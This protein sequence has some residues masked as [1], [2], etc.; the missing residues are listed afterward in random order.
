VTCTE[1]NCTLTNVCV[2][3]PQSGVESLTITAIAAAISATALI[4]IIVGIVA[5][6]GLLGGG[7]AY[8]IAQSGTGG[9][10]AGVTNNPLYVGNSH[11]GNNPLFPPL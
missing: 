10:T 11:S 1:G 2:A 3:P 5:F 7:G 9:T 8:A 6:V 4:G